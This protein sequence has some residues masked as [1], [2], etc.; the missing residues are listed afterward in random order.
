MNFILLFL[1]APTYPPNTGS[2]NPPNNASPYPPSNAP[3]YAQAQQP[4]APPTGG[5]PPPTVPGMLILQQRIVVSIL[6]LDGSQ[7][8]YPGAY[9]Q[10]FLPM[11]PGYNPYNPFFN[12]SK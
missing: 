12:M 6:A 7:L 10:P 8:P 4:S 3:P 2:Q 11:P 1:A 9:M 5:Q